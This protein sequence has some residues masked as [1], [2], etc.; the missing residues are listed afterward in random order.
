MVA[1]EAEK[2]DRHVVSSLAHDCVREAVYDLCGVDS[3]EIQYSDLGAPRWFSGNLQS[4]A[5][6]SI[7]HTGRLA[8]GVASLEPIGVDVERSNRDVG[9]L[10]RGFSQPEQ[11][12]LGEWDALEIL[13]AKEAAG[14]AQQ[15]GLAGSIQRWQVTAHAGNFIVTDRDAQSD[16]AKWV[17]EIIRD[18]IF[19]E[20]HT[21]VI[22][23]PWGFNARGA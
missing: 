1:S 20:S 3:G 18:L 19:S 5:F 13:C 6:V 10:V 15:V 9:R 12:L 4:N 14:K 22:A 11:E 21:C 7:A 17:V 2:V 23:R 8:V 16:R